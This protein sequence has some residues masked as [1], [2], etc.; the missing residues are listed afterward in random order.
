MIVS[1]HVIEEEMLF[2]K[3]VGFAFRNE[4]LM[5]WGQ[6]VVFSRN[7]ELLEDSNHSLFESKSFRLVHFWWQ[8][9]SSYV[10]GDP[11]SH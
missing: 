2:S 4:V 3:V 10:S 6:T 9:P 11:G 1:G 8:V 5:P 7:S